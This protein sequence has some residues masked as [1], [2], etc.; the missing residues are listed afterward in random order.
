MHRYLKCSAGVCAGALLLACAGAGVPRA[1]GTPAPAP[2]QAGAAEAAYTLGRGAHLARRYVQAEQLYLA[3]LRADAAHINASNGLATLYAEQGQLGAAIARWH[4][5]TSALGSA[6]GPEYAFLF[7]NLGYA[8]FLNGEPENARVALEK[9]CLL[10]P[11]NQLAWQHLG[12]ALQQLGQSERALR[13]FRQASSLQAHDIKA[14]YA[15]LALA[16]G[17]A[18]EQA[19]DSGAASAPGWPASEIVGQASDGMVTLR[20]VGAPARVVAAAPEVP[21]PMPEQ[22]RLE[23]RN[24]NGVAGMAAALGRRIGEHGVRVVRLSNE[25]GYRVQLTRLEYGPQYQL[26]A[27]ELAARLGASEL[28]AVDNCKPAD[29]R[30]V[31]GR[32]LLRATPAQTGAAQSNAVAGPLAAGRAG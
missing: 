26:A 16:A 21:G 2:T 27:S 4:A 13:M 29:V 14:D 3:A 24:G 8:Y 28:R 18:V 22:V 5:L 12:S 23:I 7:G 9:A 20:Q 32:D 19:I 10:D 15:Q 17:H 1:P 30:L 25:K 11:S 6:S 31:I